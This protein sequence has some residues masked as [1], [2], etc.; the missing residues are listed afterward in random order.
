MKTNKYGLDPVKLEERRLAQG[1]RC[2]YCSKS[3]VKPSL[4]VDR[5]NWESIEHLHRVEP[6]NDVTWVAY[7]CYSCNCSR[8]RKTLRDWFQSS[9]CSNNGISEKTVGKIVKEYLKA[10]KSY[11]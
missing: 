6:W 3:M 8:G 1:S 5:R 10:E 2:V 11:H 7:C 9:Y 4:S